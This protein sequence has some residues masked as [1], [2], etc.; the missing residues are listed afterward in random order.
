M[1]G[2]PWTKRQIEKLVWMSLDGESSSAI[3]TTLGLHEKSIRKMQWELDLAPRRRVHLWTR[4]EQAILRRMYA[5]CRTSEIAE[6]LGVTSAQIWREAHRLKLK[7]STEVIREMARER[8]TAPDHPSAR[9]RYPKG[10]VP[11]NKGL[12]RPGYAPGRMAETQFRK[13]ER[14]W[15]P[16]GS[17]IADPEGFLRVK[18]RERINGSPAG[19]DKRIWP[20]VHHRVWEQH[21][22]PVPA[23]HKVIF[24][25]GDRANCAIEN[26]ELI[27]HAEMMRRNSIHNLPPDLKEVIFL[28]GAIRRVVTI[29]RKKTA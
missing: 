27:T 11:A 22:G 17:V 1:K 23:G 10:H 2:C 5:D 13:G 8:I 29:R 26:L 19:W 25:D 14:R 20:L 3:A 28:K 16:V 7:K 18:I 6:R 9:Y 12:R 21:H 15:K 24:K 4:K